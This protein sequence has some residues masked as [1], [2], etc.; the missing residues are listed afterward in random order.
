MIY[1]SDHRC[2]SILS[3]ILSKHSISPFQFAKSISSRPRRP[4]VIE[5]TCQR[6]ICLRIFYAG[7][8]F[9]GY[10]LQPFTPNTIE[11]LLA[12]AL[13]NCALIPEPLLGHGYTRS[14]RTDKGVS[15]MGTVVG[16]HLRSR[17][18]SSLP[19]IDSWT[20]TPTTSDALMVSDEDTISDELPYALMINA[21]LPPQV[22][23][24]DWAPA[25]PG[26]HARYDCQSREYAYI[27]N[28]HNLNLDAMQEAASFFEG[29]HDLRNFCKWTK[30]KPVE[31]YRR[32]ISYCRFES[33]DLGSAYPSYVRLRVR[34]KSF[35]WHQIRCM[36]AV[37]LRVGQGLEDPDVVPRMLNVPVEGYSGRPIYPLADPRYLVLT[38]CH[39]GSKEPKWIND[40]KCT[41]YRSKSKRQ[42]IVDLAS[43]H[44]ERMDQGIFNAFMGNQLLDKDLHRK[45]KLPLGYTRLEDEKR[46]SFPAA[47]IADE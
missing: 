16:L 22:K 33:L 26:F 15:S 2:S 36:V 37:L 21:H 27:L 32:S 29:T 4:F 11:S 6:H 42:H 3:K 7:S 20:P 18:D 28:A 31:W 41:G 34:G 8:T 25:P 19:H 35:L 39:F 30:G 43:A 44:Q 12:K 5:N 47:P 24:L 14:A 10:A 46:V 1:I 17:L 23:V 13:Y 45:S 38:Q 40:Q 9:S